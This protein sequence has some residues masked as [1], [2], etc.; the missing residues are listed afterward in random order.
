MTVTK[1]IKCLILTVSW[2]FTLTDTKVALHPFQLQFTL[3][4][5]VTK[6][7]IIFQST[8]DQTQSTEHSTH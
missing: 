6:L 4:I 1:G 7:Q 5:L 3:R 2:N 8:G